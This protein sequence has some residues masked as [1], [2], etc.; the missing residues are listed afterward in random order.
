MAKYKPDNGQQT[1][2][3]PVSHVI[4]VLLVVS[5]YPMPF[6]AGGACGVGVLGLMR[7]VLVAVVILVVFVVSPWCSR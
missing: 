3:D 4:V 5:G 6:A 2:P 7:A 1:G